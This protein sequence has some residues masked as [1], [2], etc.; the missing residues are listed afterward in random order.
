VDATEMTVLVEQMEVR[1]F[2]GA[3]PEDREECGRRAFA[4]L[5]PL[6]AMTGP[7]TSVRWGKAVVR[8]ASEAEV[9]A[10][11]TQQMTDV[12][13]RKP[14]PDL[15]WYGSYQLS[16]GRFDAVVKI[17]CGAWFRGN[18]CSV[19][20]DRALSASAEINLPIVRSIVACF[21]P[22]NVSVFSNL[23]SKRRVA[24]KAPPPIVDW[25]VYIAD[26]RVP[27]EE[28]AMVHAV[29]HV[30]SGTLVILKKERLHLDRPEDLAL[31]EA[32]EPVIRR[33]QKPPLPQATHHPRH[34]AAKH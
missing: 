28:L 6:L 26:A 3:R 32:V 25:M 29:E 13:P 20:I 30:G 1:A 15:G 19:T 10:G 7:R 27:P 12:E 18:S 23:G 4:F 24:M 17:I 21:D 33:Y 16:G 9:T 31:V 34:D 2:W 22:E 11:L 14:I 8:C 5:S